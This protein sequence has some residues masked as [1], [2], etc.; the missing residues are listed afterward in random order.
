MREDQRAKIAE[1]VGHTLMSFDHAIQSSEINLMMRDPKT[2]KEWKE[3]IEKMKSANGN[4]NEMLALGM[5]K[6]DDNIEPYSEVKVPSIPLFEW[7]LAAGDW[8]EIGGV[9]ELCD[10]RQIDQGLFR[11]RIRG[12][13][14]KP[15]WPDGIIVEFKCF[16]IGRDELQI[17]RD[18]YFQQNDGT[19]TFKRLES[20]TEDDFLLRPLNK[21]YPGMFVSRG[22]IVRM[23]LAIGKF[24]PAE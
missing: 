18:Y 14:M 4:I 23:A 9:G 7:P 6:W 13:S 21:K 11:V 8:V 12:D 19:A 15:V 24:V 5:D 2:A 3:G 10:P 20:I 16:R 17:G 1:A 22:L